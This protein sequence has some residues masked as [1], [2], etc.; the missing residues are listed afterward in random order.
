MKIDQVSLEKLK[1]ICTESFQKT[2]SDTEAQEVGQRIV[3]FLK[4]SE[5]HFSP[6]GDI[7]GD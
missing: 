2:L 4:N 3:R 6:S 1:R 7:D 5:H